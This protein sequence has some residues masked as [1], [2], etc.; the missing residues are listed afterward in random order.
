MVECL[1]DCV[2]VEMYRFDIVLV[3]VGVIEA[4]MCRVV[5][6]YVLIRIVAFLSVMGRGIWLELE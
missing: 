5:S 4:A 3:V 6:R 1:V 2:L